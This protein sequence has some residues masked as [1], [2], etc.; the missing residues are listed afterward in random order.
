LGSSCGLFNY[1]FSATHNIA[2]AE[3]IIDEW[4]IEKDV[5]RS[6]RGLI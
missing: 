1:A 5:E 2:S 3:M 4:E 6:G